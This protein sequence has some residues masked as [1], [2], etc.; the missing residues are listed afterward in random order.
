M[1][2]KYTF[3]VDKK[4]KKLKIKFFFFLCVSPTIAIVKNFNVFTIFLFHFSLCCRMSLW[5]RQE[6]KF[7]ATQWLRDL[8]TVAMV[9]YYETIY[10]YKLFR[11]FLFSFILFILHLQHLTSQCMC[12][13]LY[14]VLS[15]W[16]VACSRISNVHN[17][18][19]ALHFYNK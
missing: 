10:L 9:K 16:C 4:K 13:L 12:A 2:L 1:S 6:T 3:N 19:I 5:Q 14:I 18:S 11:F 7:N 8:W 17:H 15:I